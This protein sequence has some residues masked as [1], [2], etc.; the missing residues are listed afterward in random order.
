MTDNDLISREELIS[1]KPEF[2]N[3]KVVRD[4]K[5]RTSKDRIYARAWN[6]CN[7]YWINTIKN[8]PTVDI[9]DEIA[10]A[11]N[12]GYMCGNKEAEKARPHEEP[13]L[14]PTKDLINHIVGFDVSAIKPLPEYKESE[15]ENE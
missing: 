14:K 1:A 2:M 10:G 8:A 6:A 4:T 3:E 15:A 13:E 7:S 5:Y 11:Y 12:E 9:K